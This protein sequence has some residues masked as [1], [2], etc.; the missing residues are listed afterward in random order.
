MASGAPNRTEES[1]AVVNGCLADSPS[2]QDHRPGLRRCEQTH[3][4]GELNHIARNRR[5]G[6]ELSGARRGREVG[7]VLWIAVA[8]QVEAL[9]RKSGSKLIL[10]RQRAI[11]GEYLVADAHLD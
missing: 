5:I 7:G 6:R 1:R 11:L 10:L 4:H 2:V 9:C 8:A 3:K